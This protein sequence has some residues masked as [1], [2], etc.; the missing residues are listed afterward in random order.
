MSTCT[1]CGTQYSANVKLCPHDGTVLEEAVPTEVQQLGKVL[2]GKYRLDS[3]ISRGGMGAVFQRHPCNAQQA[4]CR[5]ADQARTG[6][7]S[8]TSSAAFSARRAPR[9]T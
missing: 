1:R 3:F 8:R 7:N 9:A 6:H 2:D 5:E 4:R